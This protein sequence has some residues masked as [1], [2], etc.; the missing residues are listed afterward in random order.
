M[1]NFNSVELFYAIIAII[2]GVL[3]VIRT[4]LSLLGG[5][6]DADTDIDLAVHDVPMHADL[7]DHSV[8]HISEANFQLFSLHGITGFFMIFGLVGLSLSKAGVHELITAVVGLVAGGI[9]LLSVAGVYY[10]M[11]RLQ[12]DG[13][14]QMDT[15]IGLTGI[16]YLTIPDGGS[17]QVSIT[18]QGGLKQF[19]AISTGSQKIPTGSKIKVVARNG[20]TLVVEHVDHL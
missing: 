15:A 12:S 10:Y 2:G 16:V 8:A 18:I 1:G 5:D 19:D 9:T 7:G 17:G 14:M 3:F 13:T 20:G 11:R 6:V 4:I